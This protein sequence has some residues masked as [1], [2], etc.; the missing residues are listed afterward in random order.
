MAKNVMVSWKNPTTRADGEALNAGDLKAVEIYARQ[1]AIP[2]FTKVA[3]VTDGSESRG[4]PNTP[5][6]SWIFRVV[7][8]DSDDGPSDPAEANVTVP[9]AAIS[10]VSELRV[11]VQ[12]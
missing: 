1:A 2:E 4:F 11:E 7:A 8:I 12:P 5:S 10:P 3:T 9:K 6:G